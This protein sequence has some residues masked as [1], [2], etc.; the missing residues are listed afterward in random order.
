MLDAIKWMLQSLTMCSLP[1]DAQDK[2]PVCCKAC[3]F[4][5]ET[6]NSKRCSVGS[7]HGCS[8]SCVLQE[9]S[10]AQCFNAPVPTA[11]QHLF[12]LLGLV[13]PPLEEG[14]C[15]TYPCPHWRGLR[16]PQPP[17]P[18]GLPTSCTWK[19][20]EVGQTSPEHWGVAVLEHGGHI[21]TVHC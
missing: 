19:P 3:F 4:L 1:G 9:V 15:F 5:L 18:C 14:L 12:R 20:G 8:N 21:L 10:A 2:S 11:E 7:G 13:F 16:S 6:C 17:N